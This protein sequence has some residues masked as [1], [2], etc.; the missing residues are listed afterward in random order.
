MNSGKLRDFFLFFSFF[1]GPEKQDS[2]SRVQ[3]QFLK[4]QGGKPLTANAPLVILLCV[5]LRHPFHPIA[6]ALAIKKKKKFCTAFFLFQT[7]H[8]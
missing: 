1:G 2:R 8:C 4:P 7:A 5:E 6:I 3:G